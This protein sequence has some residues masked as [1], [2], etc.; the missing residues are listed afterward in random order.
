MAIAVAL[1]ATATFAQGT[2]LSFGT[3][4]HD[5]SQPV[6]VTSDRLNINQT[7]GTA[8]FTGNVVV[9]QGE[10]T[11]TAA[12]VVVE[13]TDT[14]PREIDRIVASEDVVLVNGAETAEGDD[15]VYTMQDRFVVMTGDVV[16][17]Q[18]DTAISGD[19]LTVNLDSGTGVMEG[20]VRTV[21]RT[22]GN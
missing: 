3:S 19:L 15:A 11:M 22:G 21:L 10:L 13:Y 12:R 5:A 7:D 18:P 8:V 2:N 4:D 16:V 9:V 17:T 1:C 6:E 20:R 14:E